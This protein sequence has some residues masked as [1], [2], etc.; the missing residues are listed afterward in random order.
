MEPAFAGPRWKLWR[1]DEDPNQIFGEAIA[2]SG[3][4]CALGK[5]AA[6]VIRDNVEQ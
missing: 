3:V 6:Q 2:E 4:L 1:S 5:V